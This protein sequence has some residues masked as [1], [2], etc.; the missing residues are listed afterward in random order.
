MLIVKTEGLEDLENQLLGLAE[1]FRT[2]LVLRNTMTKAVK[3]AME[4]IA[5]AVLMAPI[6]Y[7][8]KNTTHI[9]LRDTL[10]IDSRTP[11]ERDK[12]SAMINQTDVVIGVV[13]VKK[14]AVSLSQEFGNARVPAQPYLRQALERNYQKAIDIFSSEM[15]EL[16]PNYAKKL[17][18]RKV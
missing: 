12:Q 10:R 18:K 13:S 5:T 15:S 9:H 7:D 8:E 17:A 11:N 16:V 2:D 14:S 6:P 4:P 3:R 1:G